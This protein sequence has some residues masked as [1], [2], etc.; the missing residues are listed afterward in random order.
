MSLPRL[1]A[2]AALM[3]VCSSPVFSSALIQEQAS[4]LQPELTPELRETCLNTQF[5]V[6]PAW[7]DAI[8]SLVLDIRERIKQA[9]QQGKIVTYISM[10][11]TADNGGV[12]AFNKY[13]GELQAKRIQEQ[14]PDTPMEIILPGQVETMLPK[15]KGL[16]PQGGEYLYMWT[17]VLAGEDCTGDIDWIYY[18]DFIDLH[19]ILDLQAIPDTQKSVKL[20]KMLQHL[21]QK[22][23]EIYNEI[24]KKQESR[25]KFTAYYLNH[26]SILNSKGGRD[27]WNIIQMLGAKTH[28]TSRIKQGF[29]DNWNHSIKPFASIGYQ[30]NH[31]RLS[32]SRSILQ[33]INPEG[34]EL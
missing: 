16:S 12:R 28:N 33:S 2:T 5:F 21:A 22:H 10:P 19:V 7:N 8:T 23:P 4:N 3:F 32:P 13:L 26:Y 30:Q 31:P 6:R 24:Y 34:T 9:R 29:R 25:E 14:Y 17:Q 27:E 1:L 18:M 11:L 15:M 20:E